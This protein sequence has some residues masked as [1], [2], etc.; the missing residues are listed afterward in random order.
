MPSG[1]PNFKVIPVEI[2]D[3]DLAGAAAQLEDALNNI[4]PGMQVANV[5]QQRATYTNYSHEDQREYHYAET[6]FLIV[7]RYV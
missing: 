1:I 6:G 2:S 4:P 5:F 7:A 3:T